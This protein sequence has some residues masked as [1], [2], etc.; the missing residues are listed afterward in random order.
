METVFLYKSFWEK[1]EV[2]SGIKTVWCLRINHKHSSK[3]MLGN[4]IQFPAIS[5][6]TSN[7][8]L[9]KLCYEI[10]APTQTINAMFARSCIFESS[11]H[12]DDLLSH[13][14]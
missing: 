9:H 10:V 13:L 12:G 4:T 8:Y 1:N 3:Q 14:P 6:T 2:L 7:L 5:Y 11:N